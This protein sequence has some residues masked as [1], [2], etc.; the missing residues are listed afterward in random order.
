MWT[1]EVISAQEAERIGIVNRVVP[2]DNLI[3]RAEEM[4]RKIL[5]NIPETI[6]KMKYLINQSQ[7]LD[8]DAGLAL[9]ASQ[10]TTGKINPTEEGRKR[11]IAFLEKG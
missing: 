9:E 4:A 6:S 5:E 11:I 2:A 1:C 7:K 10:H 8:L 3:S